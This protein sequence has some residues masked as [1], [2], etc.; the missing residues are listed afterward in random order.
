MT[1]GPLYIAGFVAGKAQ[2]DAEIER[3]RAALETCASWIDRW[4]THVGNCEG[5]DKCTC[6]RTA[7][8]FEARAAAI[9]QTARETD[10]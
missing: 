4:T 6:G 2:A 10:G 3:L 7:V 5:G 8:L 1:I 9:E